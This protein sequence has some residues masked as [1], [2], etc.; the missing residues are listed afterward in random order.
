[1]RQNFLSYLFTTALLATI[2]TSTVVAQDVRVE[3]GKR[4]TLIP[5]VCESITPASLEGKIDVP[6]LVKEAICKGAGDM[7]IEYTYLMKSTERTRHKKGEIREATTTY[8]VFMPVFKSGVPAR[9]VLLV[10]ERNGIPVP[11]D[12]LEKERMRAGER[13]EKEEKRIERTKVDSQPAKNS[14]AVK[15]LIPL[16]MY[17][18]TRVNRESFGFNR[19]RAGIN[20]PAVLMNSDLAFQRREQLNGRDTLVFNFTPRTG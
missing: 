5:K 18:R 7:L 10:T 9:G 17:P 16:G 13:L 4:A 15:G 14:A 2:S 11:P 6:A 1:M 3:V 19:G 12:E 20:L 8:E